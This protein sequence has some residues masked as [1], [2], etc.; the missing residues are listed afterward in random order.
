MLK[1]LNNI[2]TFLAIY[3]L[4][5]L[6]LPSTIDHICLTLSTRYQHKSE[7]LDKYIRDEYN[8]V[9]EYRDLRVR[10]PNAPHIKKALDI[11]REVE[12]IKKRVYQI[13]EKSVA[14]LEKDKLIVNVNESKKLIPNADSLMIQ[15]K[16]GLQEIEMPSVETIRKRKNS[17]TK[18]NSYLKNKRSE[19]RNN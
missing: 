4:N 15:T 6:E 1:G 14:V 7:E 13:V 3:S 16:S 12:T 10:M 2:T 5:V 11:E 17:I 9:S 19:W 18:F 8:G